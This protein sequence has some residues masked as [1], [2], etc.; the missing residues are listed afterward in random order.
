MKKMMTYTE[1]NQVLGTSLS[2]NNYCI[3]KQTA[4]ENGAD[5]T[6][7]TTFEYNRL[8]PASAVSKQD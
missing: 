7:L 2:P 1:A 4:I 5:T 8:V 6:P 3:C